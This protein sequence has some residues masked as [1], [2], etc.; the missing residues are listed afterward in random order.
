M[1]RHQTE[2]LDPKL[3]DDVLLAEL[4]RVKT[5]QAT[6]LLEMIRWLRAKEYNERL[7]IINE[8]GAPPV[9][10]QGLI[11]E[12][13]QVA[14]ITKTFRNLVGELEELLR[15]KVSG[16]ETPT[17]TTPTEP[18]TEPTLES[19]TFE[20]PAP[21]PTPEPTPEQL[22]ETALAEEIGGENV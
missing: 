5:L 18:V 11:W 7:R 4:D 17:S 3:R 16:S 1:S 13:G 6:P 10:P 22:G 9:H 20:E 15:Q 12:A 8:L 14:G 21:E 19:P 2:L